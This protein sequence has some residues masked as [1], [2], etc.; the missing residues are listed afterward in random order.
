MNPTML[1]PGRATRAL[2]THQDEAGIGAGPKGLQGPDMPDPA[3][4]PVTESSY[5]LISA[6][7]GPD[8]LV[9]SKT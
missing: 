1:K 5:S 8:G 4:Q 2:M 9:G 3:D 7:F 6:T